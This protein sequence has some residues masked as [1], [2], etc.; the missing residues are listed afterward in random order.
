[1]TN[2]RTLDALKAKIR[3]CVLVWEASK[4][5]DANA[6]FGRAPQGRGHAEGWRTTRVPARQ[7]KRLRGAGRRALGPETGFTLYQWLVDTVHNLCSRLSRTMVTEKAKCIAA[8]VSVKYEA[9][10]RVEKLPKIT[11]NWVSGTFKEWA[12]T[13][14][15]ITI[16]YKLAMTKVCP[17]ILRFYRN[18][19][20]RQ[21]AWLIFYRDY[22]FRVCSIDQTPFYFN[23][24]GCEP[25]LALKGA[26]KIK[27]VED[28]C[29]TR[30]RITGLCVSYS[31]HLGYSP[32]TGLEN[33]PSM[34]VCTKNETGG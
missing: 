29:A 8:Q 26:K 2:K 22:L 32:E 16:Q 10:G 19:W 4:K 6:L 11:S 24:V 33:Y 31:Y 9:E 21:Q 7:R 25:T 27:V 34:C 30:A 18:L 12:V 5:L 23:S 28:F 13:S 14:R 3:R 17:R 20:R 15:V 1:M